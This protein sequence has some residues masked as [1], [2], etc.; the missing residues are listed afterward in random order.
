MCARKFF[1]DINMK[2]AT[3]QVK[4]DV[5]DSFDKLMGLVK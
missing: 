4:Y 1:D 2:F 5:V 3:E